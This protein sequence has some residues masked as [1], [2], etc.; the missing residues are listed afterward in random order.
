M[1]SRDA[2]RIESQIKEGCAMGSWDPDKPSKDAWS[3]QGGRLML[4]SLNALSLEVYY[5]YL[6]LYQLDKPSEPKFDLQ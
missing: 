6:P 4:T 5:R 1:E 3:E 2:S